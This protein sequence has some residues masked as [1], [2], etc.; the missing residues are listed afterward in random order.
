[1]IEDAHPPINTTE[2][3]GTF[4]WLGVCEA[5]MPTQPFK[6]CPRL[7]KQGCASVAG[8][9]Q[10]ATTPNGPKIG[11][12]SDPPNH[13]IVSRF[14]LERHQRHEARVRNRVCLGPRTSAAR[15]DI[16]AFVQTQSIFGRF[17]GTFVRQDPI[18]P[19]G[20]G[21]KVGVR[22]NEGVSQDV[23]VSPPGKPHD[24]TLLLVASSLWR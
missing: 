22:A 2:G 4:T 12:E 20:R 14:T 10:Q 11:S 17:L 19:E 6:W 1:M 9:C 8:F 18:F 21:R 24:E 23:G 16:L 5:S 13:E 15:E 3:Y 7:R